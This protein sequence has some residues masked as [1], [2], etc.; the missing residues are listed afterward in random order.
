MDY[1]KFLARTERSLLAYLGGPTVVSASRR[2]RV[3]TPRPAPGVHAFEVKGREARVLAGE[4]PDEEAVAEVLAPLPRARGHRVSAGFVVL[5]GERG[6]A[7]LARVHLPPPDDPAPLSLVRARR[8]HSGELLFEGLDFDG[9]AELEAR[10][11][12]EARAPL[13]DLSGVAASLRVAYGLALAGVV[14][15]SVHLPLSPREA[16]GFAAEA[17]DGGEDVARAHLARLVH[18]R[19]AEAA[20][21]AVA[22][23]RVVLEANVARRVA[24]RGPRVPPTRENAADRAEAAL[25]AT[26]ARVLSTRR[27][28][29][30]AQL[31]V[32]FELLGE[33][34]VSVVDALTLQVVDAGV[35]LAGEDDL[36]TLESLPGVIREAIDGGV[37]V[38]TRR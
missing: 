16:L 29:G 21:V 30:G 32:A 15:R 37:L 5:S 12:L 20:R 23:Q 2:L 18:A 19:Q 9:D 35:C 8:W 10:L 38:I 6:P 3:G 7:A 33:R 26:D 36:V 27:L 14:A 1:T 34:F 25:E 31:E 28:Q 4:A 11:R 17:A 22:A 24:L 13:G